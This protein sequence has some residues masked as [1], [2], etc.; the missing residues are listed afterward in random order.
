MRG[1]EAWDWRRGGSRNV[2]P[3]VLYTVAQDARRR[4]VWRRAACGVKD[5]RHSAGAT[6]GAQMISA[7]PAA[8]ARIE[9][10]DAAR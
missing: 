1:D 7:S 8:R 6:G 5:A 10:G 2:V 4:A 9:R 3:L